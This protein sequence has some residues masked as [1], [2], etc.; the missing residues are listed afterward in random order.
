[1]SRRPVPVWRWGESIEPL[2]AVVARG[3]LLGIPTGSSYGLA[4]DPC[5]REAVESVFDVKDRPAGKPLPVVLGELDQLR[6]LGGDPSSPTIR[7]LSRVWPGPLTVIVPVRAGLPVAPD[8]TL[9][10]R[11]PGHERLRRL[12]LEMGRPLTA[13][14]ANRSGE[15]PLLETAPLAELLAGRDAMIVG[16]GTLPGGEPST[17]VR[18]DGDRLTLLRRGRYPLSRLRQLVGDEGWTETFSAAIAEKPVEES[19]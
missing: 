8:A 19:G 14:S 4:V 13:T 3:G 18:V 12:L 7:R 17:I 9:G 15:Q 5:N 11:I 2:L 6:W 16:D 1:M 10:V